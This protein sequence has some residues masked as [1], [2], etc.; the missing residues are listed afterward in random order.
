[1]CADN[2][3]SSKS[4]K[5]WSDDEVQ[6]DGMPNSLFL[7]YFPYT[8][9]FLHVHVYIE[10]KAEI[11]GYPISAITTVHVLGFSLNE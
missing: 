8:L 2:N 3:L 1:M 10:V 11:L 5:T 9:M 4:N 6:R 7:F